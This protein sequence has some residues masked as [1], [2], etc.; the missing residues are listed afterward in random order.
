MK[1]T[2]TLLFLALL[3]GPLAA[4]EARS[5][6]IDVPLSNPG[7][8]VH[9]EVDAMRGSVT[10]ETHNDDAKLVVEIKPHALASLKKPAKPRPDGLKRI[11]DQSIGFEISEDG[12]YVEVETEGHGSPRV[13]DLVIHV[14]VRT[15]VEIDGHQGGSISVHG[16][17]GTHE[18]EHHDGSIEA[19]GI[20]GSLVA[21]TH[22]G[23][24]TVEMV[25]VDAG[26]PMAFSTWN[27]TID[28]TFPPNLAATLV[29]QTEHGEILTGFDLSVEANRPRLEPHDDGEGY[30]LK[31]DRATR[32]S[33][34]GGGAEIRF[35]TYNGDIIVRKAGG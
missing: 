19:R 10:V 2:T 4:Q 13:V 33:I 11:D 12:N 21:E 25:A 14:P 5:E 34:G 8:P 30:H 31:Q 28:T 29:M 16:V 17:K 23:T 6:R 35:D 15:S 3:G 1:T 9:L 18:I 27:G 7:Q 22:N 32:G 20:S 24:I 26:K